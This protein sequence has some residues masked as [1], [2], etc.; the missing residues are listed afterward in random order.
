MENIVERSA[1]V[2]AEEINQI[3]SQTYGVVMA[4]KNFAYRSCME[5]GRRLEEAKA[6]VAHGEW[7]NWLAQNVDYSESKA[8]NLMRMYREFGD[9]QIDMLTGRSEAEVF[10][11]LSQSQLVE[12]F[13]L[14]KPMRAEFVEEHRE[15]LESGEMSVREQRELIR[16]LKELVAEKDK[17]I[18]KNDV[19][20]ADL[21]QQLRA[22]ESEREALGEQLSE[23]KEDLQRAEK[24]K[25]DAKK[26]FDAASER[27]IALAQELEELKATPAPTVEQ[28][29]VTVHEPSQEQI[30]EIRAAAIAESEEKHK[31]DIEKLSSDLDEREKHHEQVLKEAQEAADKKIRQLLQK[32]DPHGSR[33]A[34]CMESIGRAITDIN[35]EIAKME[36]EEP[37]S[38]QKM[39]MRCESAMLSLINRS[40][41]QI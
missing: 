32:S 30:D 11:R 29:T 36:S 3:K 41:W 33:V 24:K 16:K 37:G 17:A 20:Y 38:G 7:G 26:A 13:A 28:I 23:A 39:K 21:V 10:E 40:G 15:E 31:N 1:A 2:I 27:N 8:E 12:L 18:E 25:E 9:E 4:A 22:S 14:P 35:A 5:I 34:Y 19:S 6:L